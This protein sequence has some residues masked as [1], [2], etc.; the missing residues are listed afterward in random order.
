MT[1]KKIFTL[2]MLTLTILAFFLTQPVNAQAPEKMSYQAVIRD[3]ANQLVANQLIGIQISI[4]QGSAEGESVYTETQNKTSNANGL[5]SLN[6]GEGNNVYGNFETIDWANGPFFI[7]TETDPKGGTNYSIS[8]ISQ[9]MSVPYALFAK[10]AESTQEADPIFSNSPSS[11]ITD[12]GSNAVITNDERNKLNNIE[13]GAEV[14][15]QSD[16]FQT[17]ETA[18]DYIKNKPDTLALS[19]RIDSVNNI[20]DLDKDTKILVEKNPDEDII[21]FEM[22]GLEKWEMV[23][24]RLEPK[25]NGQSVFIGE[26]AGTNDDLSFNRNIF[27]G[28]QSGNSNTTGENNTAIGALSFYSNTTGENNVATG[29]ESLYYNTT[30]SGNIANGTRTLYSNK[31]GSWNTAIGKNALYHNT[32]GSDNTANGTHALFSNMSGFHN[33]ANGALTLFNDTSGYNN[34]AVGARALYSSFSGFNNTAGGTEAGYSNLSGSGNIF[35]GYQAGYSET[36]SN[37]LYIEN[38]SSATPLIYGDFDKDSVKINGKLVVEK[39][40]VFNGSGSF[41]NLTVSGN[42]KTAGQYVALFEN[43]DGG[44]GDGIKIKLG[45]ASANNGFPDFDLGISSAEVEQIKNLI[46][47]SYSGNKITLLGQIVAEGLVVDAQTIGGL[48][49]GVGN[50]V[51]GFINDKLYLPLKSPNVTIV[52]KVTVFPGFHLGMPSIAGVGIPDVNISSESIGPYTLPSFT[53]FPSIPAINLSAL[54]ISEIKITDLDFWGI[55]NICFNDVVSDPLDN[56]NEF[57]QFADKNDVRMGAIKAESVANWVSNYLNPMF[58]LSLRGALTSTLDKKHAQYH[59][60]GKITEAL[61]SYTKIGVE[62]SSG[63]GDYA[64][65]LERDNPDE[66]ISAGDIVAVKAG[67]ITKDLTNAEQVMAVSEHPIVLGN[68]SPDGKS[69]LGNNVAFMGQIPV[70]LMGAVSSGDYIVAKSNIPGYGIAV[71]PENM[72]IEDFKL[73]IGRAW[74]S[75]QD[76]G[77]KMI[78]TIVGI[79]N[80]DYFKILKSY[81]QKFKDSESRLEKLEAKMDALTNVVSQK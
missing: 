31:T 2:L 63:N 79:H 68:T 27:L 52:P 74:D 4:L 15:V 41:E 59:F 19:K 16:W 61:T 46:N 40:V 66:I 81:E 28:F 45:K 58:L 30:G 17:D 73:A 71:S 69:N 77:P 55:P 26:D 64:E 60:K 70:K 67:K 8:G 56:E 43:K 35:L 25:F 18:N 38:S 1:M 78:N 75:D 3:A 9:I 24:S 7:K 22:A 80:G 39:E 49:V 34:T 36:G 5:I 14:N 76:S 48:A 37:K 50:L 13:A 20:H 65:W 53:M 6:V 12:A 11:R 42:G 57:I 10:K 44:T 23:K 47:C 29:N 54:G 33:T 32:N 51:T 21:R 62:Y 72:T